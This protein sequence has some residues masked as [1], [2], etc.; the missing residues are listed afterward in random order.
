LA[1]IEG[2]VFHLFVSG[3]DST[4]GIDYNVAF[5]GEDFEIIDFDDLA[6]YNGR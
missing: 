4:Q 5:I 1:G 3:K 6:L 2:E